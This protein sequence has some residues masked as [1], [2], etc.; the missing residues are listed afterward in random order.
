MQEKKKL[1]LST[2]IFIA[3][4]LAIIAGVALTGH[5]AIATLFEMPVLKSAITI[6]LGNMTACLITTLVATGAVALL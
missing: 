3:L 1:A 6:L 5:P 2:Q 4:V